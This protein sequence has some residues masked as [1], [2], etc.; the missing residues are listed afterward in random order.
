MAATTVPL[1]T[2]DG[3]DNTVRRDAVPFATMSGN[4][5]TAVDT[6]SDGTLVRGANARWSRF[7][8]TSPRWALTV[9]GADDPAYEAL[10]DGYVPANKEVSEWLRCESEW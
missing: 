5:P 3:P 9:Q 1:P 4:L 6:V 10:C 8:R 7:R 2:P